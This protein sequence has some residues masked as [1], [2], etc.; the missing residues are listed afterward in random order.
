GTSLQLHAPD[1]LQYAWLPTDGITTLNVQDPIVTPSAP[2]TYGVQLS[3]ACGSAFDDIFVDLIFVHASAWPDTI[4]CPGQPVRL[5]A[6]G[7]VDYSWS[8]AQ[9]SSDP[10]SSITTVVPPSRDRKST[11]L[12]SSHVE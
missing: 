7:G 12:N 5:S 8:P 6:L 10:D 2:T 1:A 4:V 9:G 11:R 3:N